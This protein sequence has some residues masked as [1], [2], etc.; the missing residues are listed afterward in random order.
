[1]MY[2]S[3]C[4]MCVHFHAEDRDDD[5]SLVTC[6]A[7]PGGIPDEIR[8]Q[9]FDHRAP[10]EG[11]NGVMFTPRDGVGQAAIEAVVSPKVNRNPAAE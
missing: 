4:P 5:T 8:R 1:M 9:G 11:D 2:H 3:L 7:F 10:F 6:T